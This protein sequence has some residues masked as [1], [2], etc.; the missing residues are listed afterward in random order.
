MIR[1]V[2]FGY[3][4]S[5]WALVVCYENSF[6]LYIKIAQRV[7]KYSDIQY[8][9]LTVDKKLNSLIYRTLF[10]V[11]MY[12]SYKLLKP[13]WF[14]WPTLYKQSVESSYILVAS[15]TLIRWGYNEYNTA[16]AKYKHIFLCLLVFLISLYFTNRVV[17][18]GPLWSLTFYVRSAVVPCGIWHVISVVLCSLL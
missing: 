14:F 12:G 8:T 4:I 2:T 7:F 6:G 11:N 5:W 15:A 18:C 16:Q 13:V 10:C 1:H 3:L 9:D 17:W